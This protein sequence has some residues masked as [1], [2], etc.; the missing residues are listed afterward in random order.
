MVQFRTPRRQGVRHS[1][2]SGPAEAG[3][4]K[5]AA[6]GSTQEEGTHSL[7]QE[8]RGTPEEGRH[9]A[10]GDNRQDTGEE[11]TLPVAEA[12]GTHPEAG[13]LPVVGEGTEK[14]DIAGGCNWQE[15]EGIE[16]VGL[17]GRETVGAVLGTDSG[18][19]CLLPCCHNGAPA[20]TGLSFVASG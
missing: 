2:W 17:E 1:R 4:R 16:R 10:E 5:V 13:T 19:G 20:E 14:G 8:G 12:G 7:V 6:A 9:T 11:G 15:G 3:T 18:Q